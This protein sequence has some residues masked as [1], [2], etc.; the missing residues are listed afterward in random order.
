MK[1]YITNI[2]TAVSLLC[3]AVAC[4][5]VILSEHVGETGYLSVS[6]GMDDEVLTKAQTP[7]KADM[8]FKLEVKGTKKDTVIA[9]HRTVTQDKP[10][11]LPVGRYTLAA[12]YGT[13]EAIGFNKP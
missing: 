2:L 6:L 11:E 4:N 10:I 13:P 5:D 8:A 3:L 7:P 12:T 9:D 1:R